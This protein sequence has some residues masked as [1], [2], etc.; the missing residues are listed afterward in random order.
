MV[1]DHAEVRENWVR[2]VGLEEGFKCVGA[3]SSFEEALKQA[4]HFSPD[5]VIVAGPPAVPSRV[6]RLR[7]LKEK[8]PR[9]PLLS[10][11]A[12]SRQEDLLLGLRLA[13][14]VH[15]TLLCARAPCASSG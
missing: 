13:R 10:L 7:R 5:V 12:S 4:P 1:E 15:R 6:E 9:V 14:V 8:L 3:C 2:L 11:S